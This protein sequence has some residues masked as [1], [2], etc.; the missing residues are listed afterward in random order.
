MPTASGPAGRV[1][2]TVL[3]TDLTRSTEL[4]CQ[5]GGQAAEELRRKHD[6]L[7]AEAVEAHQG[8]VVKGLGDGIMA[9]FASAADAVAA[10]VAIQQ[11]ID[12]HNRSGNRIAPLEVR[13][14]LSAGDVTFE[15]GDCFGIPVVEASRLGAAAAGGQI[16]VSEVVRLLAGSGG[17]YRF[18]AVGALELKGLP[19]AVAACEL[20]WERSARSPIPLPPL[21]TDIGRIFVGREAE[22]ERLEQLWKEASVG[23]LRVAL[24]AGEPGVGKTRLAV[25]LAAGV[26]EQGAIVLAGRCD[27]ELGVPYQPFVEAL[28]HFVDH[29]PSAD[30][31]GRLGRYGAE[32]IRLVPELDDRV[33][34]LAAPLRSDPETERYRLF[35]AVAAWLGAVS[36]E[37]P[38][39]LVLDDLQ[40]AAK[41]TLLLLRHVVR[42]PEANRLLVLGTYRDTELRHDHPLVEL[43]ADLRR[44]P[45][46]ERLSLSGLDQ[47][48]VLSFMVEAA[49]H[50]MSDEGLALSRAIHTET[51][52]NPFFVREVIRHLAETGAIEQRDG[53]WMTRRPVEELGIPEGVREVVG[54][55]L[56][57]LSGQANRAL[58]VAAVVG[59]EFEPGV[60]QVAGSFDE[61]ALLVAMEEAIG[62]RLVLEIPGSAPRHRFAH[63]LVRDTLYGELSA[64]RRATMHRRVAEAI[65]A[66]HADR[67][68]DHLP[69]LAYHYGAAAPVPAA[70]AKAVAYATRA[71]DRALSQLAH[72]EAVTYYRQALELLEVADTTTDEPRRVDLLI[73]LG[74]AERRAGDAG[75]RQTLLDAARLARQSG[76]AN[77]LARAAL[78]NYRG[79]WS[80]T[81]TVDAE[82]VAVLESALDF[83]EL[84]ESPLRARLLANLAAEL[85]YAGQ[86]RR[87]RAV[88][89]E[90]LATALRLGDPAT[91]AHVML[92]R[93][94]AVWEPSTCGERLANTARLLTV[95]ARLGD[96][97]V[98]AWTWVWRMVAATELADIE[99]AD[100]SL[101]QFARLA[102]ELGQPMMVWAAS[103]CQVCRIL[104]A[105][106]LPEAE[107]LAQKALEQGVGAGQPDAHSLF[108]LQRFHIRFEQGR[109]SELIDRVARALE[110]KSE[111]AHVRAL[112]A[113]AYCELD[114]DDEARRVFEP[115][116]VTLAERPV[117]VGWLYDVT[118]SA[119]VSAKLAHRSLAAPLLD[120][121]AP[122]A[123]QL[124]GIGLLCAG[125][126]SHYLGLLATTLTR[127]EEAEERFAAAAATHRRIGAPT[128]LA[129]TR[130]EWARMLLARRRPGDVDRA[131]DL[132]G[133]AIV[134]ARELGLANV[135]RRSVELLT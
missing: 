133:Q 36:T 31:A 128:W 33:P 17:A 26:H 90:A 45:G 49:G 95:A 113:L 19:G 9:S 106:R 116:A 75:H 86:G 2:A 77:A 80:V 120:L 8:R 64:V 72:D 21:L 11:A 130:L 42:S 118:T 39:L 101:D 27:E 20:A 107:R 69:A 105:G 104:L 124:A 50:E 110:Q 96:P 22:L 79:F 52:G 131:Q 32:L 46:V 135:E 12:R 91:L 119:A 94:A 100:R 37:A 115:L 6:R 60:V 111:G 53:R 98:V 15:K 7:L 123:D 117:D 93:C 70:A 73:A 62:A 65:E 76:D 57:R 61:E 10:S 74:E 35:D 63:A 48:A 85:H 92:G 18:L 134:T 89:D 23:D 68:E 14:G 109:L 108:G 56:A 59:T 3:F 112:L 103:Y 41:P 121:L 55:R 71:G 87:R 4:R 82:R 84:S 126:V 67:L 129:R 99:E 16:L 132:L 66:T 38:F 97:A 51:E 127:F 114:R 28:R 54:R 88:S 81:G 40:W 34:G 44:Q 5:L 122:Y 102:T 30:L 1:T 78:A 24:L 83:G 43:L 29:I 13:I 125:S 47:A 25:E 58:R